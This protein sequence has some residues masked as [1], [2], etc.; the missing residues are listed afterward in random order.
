MNHPVNRRTRTAVALALAAFVVMSL[1][2]PASA[3]PLPTK[4]VINDAFEPGKAYDILRV[5]LKAQP[6]DGDWAKVR[7]LHSREVQVGDSIDVWFNLDG[8]SEPD[9]HVVGDAFSEYNVYKTNN[10]LEDGKN[11]SRRDCFRLR[12]SSQLSV[13]RFD[14][15]CIGESTRFGVSIRSSRSDTPGHNDWVRAPGKFTK[16]VLSHA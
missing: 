6:A 4:R 15:D 10:F 13:V 8:D 1:A 9:I 14:P 5:T 7:V 12:M 16:K 2:A 3:A 11:I